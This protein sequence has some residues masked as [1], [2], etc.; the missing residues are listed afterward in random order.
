M[1]R[2][3]SL[4]I[5]EILNVV[6]VTERGITFWIRETHKFDFLNDNLY[7]YN[8]KSYVIKLKNLLYL[9]AKKTTTY[10]FSGNRKL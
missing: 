1:R 6:I 2:K 5:Y 7:C 4:I 3:S 10:T 9:L 8:F